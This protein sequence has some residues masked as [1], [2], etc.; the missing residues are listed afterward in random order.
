M[1]D[2]NNQENVSEHETKE[3]KESSPVTQKSWN[4]FRQTGLLTLLNTFL[5]IFGWAIV[6]QTNDDGTEVV[7]PARTVFRGFSEQSQSVAYNRI[8]KYMQSNADI[9]VKE[10]EVDESNA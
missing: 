9:L 7:Y 2:M 1:A 4:E 6:I 3:T 10:S 8:S 5:H